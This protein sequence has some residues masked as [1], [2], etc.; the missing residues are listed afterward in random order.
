MPGVKLS[1]GVWD[2]LSAKLAERAGFELLFL[3]GFAV[4]GTQLGE[5]DFGLLTQTETLQ[6]ARRIVEAVRTPLIVDGDTGHGGPLNGQR[7]VRGLVPL[8]AAGVLLEGPVWPQRCGHL[9]DKQASAAQ[10]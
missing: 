4:A 1:V 10:R 8:G 9:R 5:P 6:A 2:V 3:S 7:L